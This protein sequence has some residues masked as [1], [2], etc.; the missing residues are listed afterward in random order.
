MRCKH[1]AVA[2]S[3][4]T[5]SAQPARI[6][7]DAI[8]FRVGDVNEIVAQVDAARAAELFPLGDECSILI[9]KL[10][11]MV[12]AV[13][14]E[15]AAL[16]IHCDVMR[17]AELHRARAELAERLHEFAV[18]LVNLEMRATVSGGA[19]GCCPL[20]PSAMKMSPFGAT[21][22]LVGSVSASGGLPATP[23]LPM[24][25]SYSCRRD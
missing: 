9:E 12:A 16:R 4:D 24:L 17:C 10:N 23:G 11:A 7:R 22:M 8:R 14:H 5:D 19:F 3:A 6:G 15:Q 25:S 2:Q 13:G 20:C 1:G 18:S 21:T